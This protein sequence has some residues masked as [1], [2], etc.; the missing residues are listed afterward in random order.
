[1]PALGD[2][3]EVIP[4]LA[5]YFAAKYAARCNRRITGI[6][7]EAMDCLA[8]YGWPG[9]VRELENAIERAVVICRGEVVQAGDLSA[10]IVGSDA[11]GAHGVPPIPGTTL[12]ELEKFAI[13]RTLEH[14]GGST[15]RAAEILGISTR[16]IQYKLHEYNESHKSG[17]PP[18]IE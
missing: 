17:S 10:T 8:G 16:K 9:N 2:R 12:A 7:A 18:T 4:L 11:P 6:T 14:T 15:S 13:L 3:R 5:R 1:M